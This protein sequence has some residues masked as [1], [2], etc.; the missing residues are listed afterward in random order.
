M[1][2]RVG[3]F[4]IDVDVVAG[5]RG[6][7]SDSR[8]PATD[9]GELDALRTENHSMWVADVSIPSAPITARPI[10]FT[11]LY[12]GLV[13]A[14]GGDELR[15]DPP[16]PHRLEHVRVVVRDEVVRHLAADADRV[17]EALVPLDEFLHRDRAPCSTPLRAMASSSSSGVVDPR[18]ARRAGAVARL[19]DE[20][21]AD[22]ARRTG[23]PRRPS[24]RRSKQRIAPRPARS[25]S[26]IAGLSRH[27]KAVRTLVPGMPHAARTFAAAMMCASTVASIRSTHTIRCTVCTA[28]YSCPSSVTEPICS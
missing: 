28:S 22:L 5:C 16:R 10:S 25:A 20:R 19:D 11:S 24:G 1:D 6:P 13:D 7:S 2:D 21:V 8:R 12:A 15:R 9:L 23:G 17:V 4:A 18:R 14:V 3:P 27:R 26:F